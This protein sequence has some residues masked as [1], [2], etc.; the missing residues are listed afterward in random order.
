MADDRATPQPTLLGY[1]AWAF[2]R[3]VEAKGEKEGTV[4]SW[5]IGR[6]VDENWKL[7]EEHFG[8]KRDQYQQRRKK[9]IPHPSS[10]RR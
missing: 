9:V 6:W 2:L 10:R 3:L 8:I 4:A 5:I 1:T 7:L